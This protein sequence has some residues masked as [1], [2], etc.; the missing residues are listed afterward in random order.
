ML[1]LPASRIG[2]P[3]IPH[4][5]PGVMASGS[6]NVFINRLPAARQGDLTIPHLLPAGKH[7]AIHV[8]PVAVGSTRVRINMRGAGYMGAYIAGCTAIAAGS[9]NVGVGV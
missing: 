8:A 9:H 6:P 3:I 4:C 1:G 7:C 5:G 2:D